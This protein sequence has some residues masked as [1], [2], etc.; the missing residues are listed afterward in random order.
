MSTEQSGVSAVSGFEENLK[1]AMTE[2]LILH[3]LSEKECYI[4]ELTDALRTRSNGVL[5]IVFPY[6]AIYRLQQSGYIS[7]CEKR[8]SPDGRRRQYF[9]IT[10]KGQVYLQQLKAAYVK[11]SSGVANILSS[12]GSK[13]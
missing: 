2:M 11:F 5:M 12:G 3:L 10:A 7:E 13:L 9:V 1:K 4:G 6:S 8:L